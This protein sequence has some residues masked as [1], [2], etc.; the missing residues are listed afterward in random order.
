VK[1]GQSVVIDNRAGAGGNVG[2]E[3]AARAAPTATRC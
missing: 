3:I 2:A 1:L